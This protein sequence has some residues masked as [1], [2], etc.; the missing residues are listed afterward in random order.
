MSPAELGDAEE[1]YE[2]LNEVLPLDRAE[3][4]ARAAKEG[5]DQY[6]VLKKDIP[7]SIKE[8]IQQ[9]IRQLRPERY[10]A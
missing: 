3:F 10:L 6:E 4:F 2:H 8:R 7:E 5:T 1:I 9:K